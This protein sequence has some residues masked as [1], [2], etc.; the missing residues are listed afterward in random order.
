MLE[1]LVRSA[2][3]PVP[4]DNIFAFESIPAMDQ[5]NIESVAHDHC[6]NSQL[7]TL[8][9][10]IIKLFV[11]IANQDGSVCKYTVCACGQERREIKISN[12]EHCSLLLINFGFAVLYEIDT[13]A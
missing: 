13:N 12:T 3:S 1:A 7:V 2:F 9:I 10:S 11:V 5:N 8:V 6:Y 4:K